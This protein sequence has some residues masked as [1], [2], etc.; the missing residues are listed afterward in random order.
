MTLD[1]ESPTL[2]TCSPGPAYFGASSLKIDNITQL[3]DSKEAA[4][5][6][7]ALV[8]AIE[9]SGTGV[10]NIQELPEH[11]NSVFTKDTAVCTPKGYVRLRMGLPS[12]TG[13]EDWMADVLGSLGKKR[14][15]S[16]ELPGTVEG[17]DIIL[18]EN[19]AFIGH[20]SRTNLSGIE[21]FS[22]LLMKFG[23]EIRIARVPEPF[24]H[25]GGTLTLVS[26]D[27]ILCVGGLFPD[28]LFNGFHVIEVPN[29]GFISGNV[30][31]LPD[32]QVIA[33]Q[34]NDSTISALKRE[35]FTVYPVDLSEFI[36][37]TGGPSCL[38]LK[39]S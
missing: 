34:S 11:P 38:I 29:N 13:E 12:R 18:A 15:G 26:K 32:K 37:G 24:L 2:I 25:L 19:I 21:Q 36:K 23:Y 6:H 9:Q 8:R 14:I 16:I 33:D 7:L 30:I 4:N 35:G 39:V 5:Q 1:P 27:T 3:P 31:A 10:I 20:S 22:S 17:G 28:S